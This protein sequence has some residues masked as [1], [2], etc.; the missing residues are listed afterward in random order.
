MPTDGGGLGLCLKPFFGP[1]DLGAGGDAFDFVAGGELA[2]NA[3][4]GAGRPWYR[5]VAL[6][7]SFSFERLGPA[8]G[9]RRLAGVP[10]A[11]GEAGRGTDAGDR[12]AGAAKG[13]AFRLICGMVV[14]LRGVPIKRG[15]RDCP[16]C[17]GLTVDGR[18]M[19]EGGP[20]GACGIDAKSSAN[21]ER[22]FAPMRT[23]MR[24]GVVAEGVTGRGGD[25]GTSS[26]S[27]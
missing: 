2:L 20:T 21:G 27:S 17:E 13:T 10:A 6:R 5:G 18:G 3:G 7:A 26:S 16:M 22:V 12:V 23:G 14:L 4:R 1:T 9:L 19:G 8:R 11:A 15:K 24:I 25:T